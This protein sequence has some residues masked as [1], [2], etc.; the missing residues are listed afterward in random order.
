MKTDGEAKIARAIVNNCF[1]P[2]EILSVSSVINVSYPSGNLRIK[3]SANACFAAWT[4]SSSVAS[5][6]L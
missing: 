2:P 3:S 4:T 5:G 1:C 6:R